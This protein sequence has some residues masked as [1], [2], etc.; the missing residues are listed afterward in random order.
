MCGGQSGRVS[1]DLEKVIY[2]YLGDDVV[3]HRHSD[4]APE[5]VASERS[6][7]VL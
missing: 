1:I 6:L 4:N 7:R 3:S 5:V 2:A